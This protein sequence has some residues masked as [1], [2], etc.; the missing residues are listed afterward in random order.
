MTT[1]SKY[2]VVESKKLLGVTDLQTRFFE[3]LKEIAQ[4]SNKFNYGGRHFLPDG[5][6]ITAD[7][8]D[9]IQLNKDAT[10]VIGVDGEGNFLDI[11]ESTNDDIQFENASAVDYYVALKY[12]A[13][14]YGIVVN[15]RSGAPQYEYWEDQIG[16]AAEPSSVVDNGGTI[17]FGV[18]SVTEDNVDNTGRK[19]L[20]W[21]K[22]PDQNATTEAVAI[23]EAT[24]AYVSTDNQ[25][26]TTG[27]LGQST[28]S[29]TAS[30]YMV[31][32][33]GPTVKKNTDLRTQDGY[34]FVGIVT[35][36]GAGSPPT[37]FDHSDQNVFAGSWST[38][39]LD[40]FDHDIFPDTTNTYDCG[41]SGK[42][43]KDIWAA[44]N[45]NS[46]AQVT[47]ESLQVTG[48]GS[49][50]TG[51]KSD[52]I[53]DGADSRDLGTS[54]YYFSESYVNNHYYKSQATFDNEDDLALI[55]QFKP[56]GEI[57]EKEKGGVVREVQQSDQ[58][59]L[60]W[61]MLGPRNKKGEQFI[62]LADST[63]FLLGA[64][65]QLYRKHKDETKELKETIEALTRRLD[66]MEKA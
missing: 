4:E 9:K 62:D 13:R 22:I 12:C 27:T 1:G 25:I 15:P 11:A 52:L 42:K 43:W 28:V 3:Y 26:T 2:I 30:D 7:G 45:I 29:T 59:S 33:L 19:V 66:T 36:V 61:P 21:K 48:D 55:E 35:G 44:G 10:D 40:G 53:P 65:K 63:G 32:C 24:V 41:V 6:T 49:T 57:I 37:A 39:V 17:T 5:V 34:V 14:P 50:S 46:A 23:E 20:V 38:M 60:P 54:T 16:E 64:I 8:N 56:S 47:G 18:N 51:L 31:A 58:S